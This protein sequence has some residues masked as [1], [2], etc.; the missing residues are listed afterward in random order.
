MNT[1]AI[2]I[3][4]AMAMKKSMEEGCAVVDVADVE[5]DEDDIL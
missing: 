3:P 1:K 2:T 4:I 5:D